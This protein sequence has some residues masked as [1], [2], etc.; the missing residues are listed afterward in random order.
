VTQDLLFQQGVI[1]WCVHHPGEFAF[2]QDRLKKFHFSDPRAQKIWPV[3]TEEFERRAT[4]PTQAEAERLIRHRMSKDPTLDIL[5]AYLVDTW[6]TETTQYTGDEVKDWLAQR[7]LLEM[8]NEIRDTLAKGLTGQ[9]DLLFKWQ[10]RL[11]QVRLIHTA[12]T[13]GEEFCPLD[14]AGVEDIVEDWYG[15]DPVPT[16]VY[17]LDRKIRDG[18]M[19]SHLTLIVGPSGTGKT[20]L[21]THIAMHNLTF[22]RRVVYFAL[23]DNPAELTER[24]W[25]CMLKRPISFRDEQVNGTLEEAK[26]KIEELKQSTYIGHFHGQSLDPE[27]Y[28]PQDLIR[29][30]F[31]L[32]RRFHAQDRIDP[33]VPEEEWGN[34]D[35]IVIDTADQ[36]KP[37]R[38]YRAEWKEDEKLFQAL[39]LIPKRLQ[40][41]TILT[42]QGNQASVGASQV[43]LRNVGG[44]YG[45]VKPAKLIISFAQTYQQYHSTCTINMGHE[46][47]A[48]NLKHMVTFDPELDRDTQW[49]RWSL[50]VIKNTR[51][52]SGGGA[53]DKVK[54]PMLVDYATNRIVEDYSQAESLITADKVTVREEAEADAY[55]QEERNPQRE[56]RQSTGK[57]GYKG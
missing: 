14:T 19:R 15:G 8:T 26:R 2:L 43:T 17:R 5:L 4:F 49:Q 23:D 52:R 22:G 1:A 32:Q 21:A 24:I 37:H 44:S 54:L 18:G 27:T 55:Q 40:A 53:T 10:E 33:T 6:R 50:C 51:G 39:G 28:T 20:V 36:I 34:I 25:S 38:H 45:K 31:K 12:G 13:A 56:Q 11:E 46:L 30:L 9:E 47:I 48:A 16:G 41:A 7:E 29:E 35:L 57:K 3:L 42:V